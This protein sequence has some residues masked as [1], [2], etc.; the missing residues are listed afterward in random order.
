MEVMF[1]MLYPKGR[2]P[3]E[4]GS[5]PGPVWINGKRRMYSEMVWTW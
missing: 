1:Q 5:M 4:V 2:R 3:K